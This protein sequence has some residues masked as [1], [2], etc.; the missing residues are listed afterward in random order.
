[1]AGCIRNNLSSYGGDKLKDSLPEGK[2]YW[3]RAC[4]QARIYTGHKNLRCSNCPFPK[5][6]ILANTSLKK[7]ALMARIAELIDGFTNY[8]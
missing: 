4:K 5:E 3:S 8:K 2:T 1:M 7:I 6:C